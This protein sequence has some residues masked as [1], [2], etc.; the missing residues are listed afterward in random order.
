LDV[1]GRRLVTVLGLSPE[2]W[3]P[4]QQAWVQAWSLVSEWL[5]EQQAWVQ[6]CWLV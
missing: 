5:P 3:L 6:A 4:E 2:E 1:R